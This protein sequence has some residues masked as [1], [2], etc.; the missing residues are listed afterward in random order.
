MTLT[1]LLVCLLGVKA[2]GVAFEPVGTTLEQAS[3]K[4]KQENKL[5]FLD[6]YTQWCGP[7]KMM[8]RQVFPQP[9]VGEMMNARYVSLQIDMES[10]Y[11]VTLAR[12]LQ[13]T[14]YPTFVV[15]NAD[16][17]EIG[18]FVGACG[19]DEFLKR[20]VENSREDN[21]AELKARW[22]SGDRDEQFMLE[23]LLTLTAAYKTREA[24]EVAEALLAG[25]EKTF[26]AD[27][28]L[29]MVFLRHVNNP[30]SPS[31][32]YTARHPEQLAA[33][34]GEHTVAAKV[35]NVLE[36]Y[37]KELIVEADGTAALDQERFDAYT[38]LL[39]ELG[40]ADAD[41]Y[42]LQTLIN[43]ADKQKDYKRY[44]GYIKE[45]LDNSK[46]DADDMQLAR[47]TNPF[48]QP[49]ID[50]AAKEQMKGILRQRVEDIRSG[51]R[52]AQTT[53]GNMRLARPTDELLLMLIDAIDGKMPGRGE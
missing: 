17:E 44:V 32:I 22:E 23:Y 48:A 47:W 28:T 52:K 11:G 1:A 20:V 45:Y 14:A 5:V 19:A 8:A 21:S 37:P 2:Q 9:M 31:F 10:A 53:V 34:V 6:C 40:V 33:A 30:F 25:K 41:K 50:E 12:R 26:A 16:A 46:L 15:F 42:R 24:G 13:V 3:A 4:A 49:G 27:S 7:C 38:R 39:G 35:M 29:R 36:N 43:L 51:K 18:R